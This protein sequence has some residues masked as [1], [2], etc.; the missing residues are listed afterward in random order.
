MNNDAARE[1]D[2][3][4]NMEDKPKEDKPNSTF[5]TS[6]VLPDGSTKRITKRRKS[7]PD[8]SVF[9][10]TRTEK[11][12]P[13]VSST[14]PD[15][16]APTTHIIKT[17]TQR[18]N[19][20]GGV[21]FSVSTKEEI[22]ETKPI[23]HTRLLSDGSRIIK[24][25]RVTV[26][27]VI[28]T[29]T[30][31]L[32][33]I[34]NKSKPAEH[35]VR[36]LITD[37][38]RK[39]H[40]MKLEAS[41]ATPQGTTDTTTDTTTNTISQLYVCEDN[42]PPPDTIMNDVDDGLVKER[43]HDINDDAIPEIYIRNSNDDTP[44]PMPLQYM[45]EYDDE[46][47]R[48]TLQIDNKRHEEEESVESVDDTDRG[49][50]IISMLSRKIRRRTRSVAPMPEDTNDIG[51]P[52]ND[53]EMQASTGGEP[54]QS[55]DDEELAVAMPVEEEEIYEAESYTPTVKVP[56]YKQRRNICLTVFALVVI[57]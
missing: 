23:T 39:L 57:R 41:T 34:P 12:I 24:T 48:K 32:T 27:P 8:G 9:T 38:S 26:G 16:D 36:T 25:K 4:M 15:T 19:S 50:G 2:I 1:N 37:E 13:E 44:P 49:A 33:N 22:H 45:N 46:A 3:N 18:V 6:V 51:T 21:S 52:V 54:V 5:T 7:L 11:F 40:Q 31:H 53:A 35:E 30:V 47:T 29:T 20:G 28:T 43:L 55:S 56:F 17:H 42:E 14:S 10:K